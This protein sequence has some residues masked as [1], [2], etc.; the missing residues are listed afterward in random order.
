MTRL[1]ARIS[2]LERAADRQHLYGHTIS[3]HQHTH[4]SERSPPPRPPSTTHPPTA[5]PSSNHTQPARL[6]SPTHKPASPSPPA[7]THPPQPAPGLYSW[8][9]SCNLDSS[10]DLPLSLKA[11]LRQ[12]LIKLPPYSSSSGSS[13][14]LETEEQSWQG[15]RPL[16][17]TAT[18][19]LSF[20]P[21]TY[22]V[23]RDGSST[24]MEVE[25]DLGSEWRRLSMCTL[26]PEEEEGEEMMSSLTGMLRFVN[27]T[28][29]MQDD[30]SVCSCTG[31]PEPRPTGKVTSPHLELS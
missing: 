1:Q 12:A 18:S 3:L 29:A 27:Q 30:P 21:L 9:Q 23:D 20:D 6:V 11:G 22:M 7:H 26:V 19:D 25:E 2:S 13:S 15:L 14:S 31:P 8:L 10:S 16:E 28:L 17:T 4:P 5:V 24:Q